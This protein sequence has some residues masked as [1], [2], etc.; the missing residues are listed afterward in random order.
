MSPRLRY[1]L[2]V[3]AASALLFAVWPL[4]LPPATA[5]LSP[6]AAALRAV[7]MA[8]PVAVMPDPR[9]SQFLIPALALILCAR[10]VPL[11]RRARFAV[12]AVVV[13]AVVEVLGAA[14]DIRSIVAAQ[15]VERTLGRSAVLLVYVT[16]QF[17]F[18]FGI[19]LAFVRGD[20]RSLWE[21]PSAD[22]FPACPLCG[23]RK[24]D[25]AAHV[26]AAHGRS[27]LRNPKVRRLLER[28]AA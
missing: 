11:A 7:F 16:F 23:A 5:L 1:A 15:D 20:V 8:P 4:I 26:A 27:A 17:C 10:S 25:L 19:L 3:L 18:T 14:L 13:F 28:P 2:S 22:R 12:V 24:V 21:L 6:A 9:V